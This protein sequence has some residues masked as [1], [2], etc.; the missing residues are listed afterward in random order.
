MEPQAKHSQ[1]IDW[2]VDFLLLYQECKRVRD[3]IPTS[4]IL[5]KKKIN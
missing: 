3:D 2:I 4:Q 1:N 5:E